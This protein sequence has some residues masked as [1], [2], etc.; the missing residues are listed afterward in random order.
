MCVCVGGYECGWADV[1]VGWGG[2]MCVWVWVR[3]CVCVWMCVGKWMCVWVEVGGCV[4]GWMCGWICVGFLCELII[5]PNAI[6]YKT[7]VQRI[8][9]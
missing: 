7:R 5:L 9:K 1:S 3:G 6:Y 4:S 2:W 8:S